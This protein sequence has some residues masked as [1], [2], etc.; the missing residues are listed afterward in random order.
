MATAEAVR[1][2]PRFNVCWSIIY[3]GE[4]FI[5]QGTM[6]DISIQGGRFAGTMPV[7]PGMR[8]GIYVDPPHKTEQLFLDEAVVTWV[9]GNQFGTRFT[10]IRPQDLQWLAGYLDVAE[11]RTSFRQL[12]G[13][14]PVVASEAAAVPLTLSVKG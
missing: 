7:E 3:R 11:R 10:K 13:L 6:I 5:G 12:L 2:H 14:S 8:L 4:D 1:T 9:S